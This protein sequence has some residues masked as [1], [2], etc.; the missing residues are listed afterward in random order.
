MRGPY[1]ITALPED[2][3]GLDTELVAALHRLTLSHGRQV[4]PQHKMLTVQ[5]PQIV[6]LLAT[7][8][9]DQLRMCVSRMP[10]A[11]SSDQAVLIFVTADGNNYLLFDGSI[12]I[13]ELKAIIQA[14]GGG[15]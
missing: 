8:L 2:L 4:N 9:P 7:T 6:S 14:L 13:E 15:P 5:T 12:D 10:G 3:S 11:L 1:L